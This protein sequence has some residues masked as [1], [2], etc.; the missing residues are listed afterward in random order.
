MSTLKL[1]VELGAE[2]IPGVG[3]IIDAGLGKS[4]LH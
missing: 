4:I 1:V 2:F 3:K